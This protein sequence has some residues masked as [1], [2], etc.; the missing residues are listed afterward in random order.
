MNFLFSF[1]PVVECY[2]LKFMFHI[3]KMF[4]DK[5]RTSKGF[6]ISSLCDNSKDGGKTA[7]V[8]VVPSPRGYEQRGKA[9]K[10]AN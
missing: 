3:S 10:C 5:Q 9:C 1:T 8:Q 7:L 4:F 6:G 2:F